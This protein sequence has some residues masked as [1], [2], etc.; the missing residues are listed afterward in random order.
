M[1]FLIGDNMANFTQILGVSIVISTISAHFLNAEA[2]GAERTPEAQRTSVYVSSSV[3]NDDND[4]SREKP[5]RTFA[6]IPRK[7][8]NIFLM[9]GDVFFGPL[10]GLDNCIVDSYGEGAKPKISG[11]KR[12]RNADAWEKAGDGVWKI[13]MHAVQ[14]FDGY[15]SRPNYAMLFNNVGAIYDAQ[16]DTVHGRLVRYRNNMSRDWDFHTADTYSRDD[17]TK[18]TFRWLYVKHTDNPSKNA[19]LHFSTYGCG[20]D[21]LR[22]CTVRNIS[23]TGFGRHGIAGCVR[24][25]VFDNVTIDIIGGSIQYGYPHNWVRLG[26]GIEFWIAD[27]GS[28]SDILVKNCTVSRTYD[29][30]AT[31]QGIGRKLQNPKNIKFIGN[32]FVHCRQAFEHFLSSKEGQPDYENCEFSE[33]KCFEMGYNEFDSPEPRD[34]L[35][36]SYE[37]SGKSIKLHRNIS[38][39]SSV[40]AGNAWSSDMKDNIFY[41]FKNKQYLSWASKSSPATIPAATE[42]DIDEYR[43]RVGDESSKIYLIDPGDDGLR[44]K[45]I[46]GHFEFVKHRKTAGQKRQN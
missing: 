39:G 36:L 22:N 14:N 42:R 12:L 46:N 8:A 4:G 33:N 6:K 13:D 9:S 23:I 27:G 5:L 21:N 19:N 2:L 26:N 38:Y 24:N 7:N 1:C 11:F 28:S 43:K 25:C 10:S 41:V 30:G 3:G 32:N 15:V 34:A 40:Y 18:E 35:F 17:L 37:K 16:N 45:L 20:M 29:C 31:I 44:E